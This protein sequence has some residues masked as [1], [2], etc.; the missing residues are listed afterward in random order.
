MTYFKMS[1]LHVSGVRNAVLYFSFHNVFK[2]HCEL[3]PDEVVL[4]ADHL[5]FY[6]KSMSYVKLK[7]KKSKV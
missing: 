2:K 1:I 4:G 3:Y 5:G 7:K 6:Y